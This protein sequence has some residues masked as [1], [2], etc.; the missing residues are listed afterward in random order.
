MSKVNSHTSTLFHFTKSQNS[1]FSILKQGIKFSFCKEKFAEDVVVGIPMISFCDIPL[2]LCKEHQ[3]KYGRY[4][5]G[6]SKSAFP[7]LQGFTLGPVSYFNNQ[8]EGMKQIVR[9]L[10]N[11]ADKSVGWF[12]AYD[13]MLEPGKKKINYDE[14]EWRILPNQQTAEADYFWNI[15]EFEKWADKREDK[16]LGNDDYIVKFGV[17][18]IRYIVVYQEENVKSTVDR[19]TRLQSIGGAPLATDEKYQLVSKVIS[20]DHINRD[21]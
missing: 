3:E 9:T 2:M 4:S 15:D 17:D 5:I 7:K 16:F 13:E 6:F 21:F 14:C 18:D 8:Q 19:L 11:K 12:K 10:V 1:L 20:F